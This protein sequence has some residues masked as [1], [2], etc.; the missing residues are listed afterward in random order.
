MP[1]YQVIRR[2]E[3]RQVATKRRRES[4]GIQTVTQRKRSR[5]VAG[6]WQDLVKCVSIGDEEQ[7]YATLRTA[8]CH[9][10]QKYRC[11]H[12]VSLWISLWSSI[13]PGAELL[14]LVSMGRQCV[15]VHNGPVSRFLV[16]HL[17]DLLAVSSTHIVSL[18]CVP[19]SYICR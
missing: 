1:R 11:F 5:N 15:Y 2:G 6:T 9:S 13:R 19:Y 8:I 4:S 17:L 16:F 14:M 10:L 3:A 7:R 12:R 18:A